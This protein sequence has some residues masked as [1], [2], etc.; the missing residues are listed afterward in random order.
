MSNYNHTIYENYS[1]S[2][3]TALFSSDN[4]QSLSFSER[5]N[6]CQEIE[7]RYAAENNVQPCTVTHQPMNGACYGWQNGNTICLNSYLVAD[8]QFSAQYTDQNGNVQT[9][10]TNALAP[11][12]NTLDTVYHE[13][14]HGIQEQTGRMPS[15][16]ISPEMDGDLYRIQGIEK[17]AYAVG[18]TKTLDALS[19]Y[20]KEVGHLDASRNDYI[21]SVR[22]DSFQ[23]ALSEAARNY[24]DPNVEQTLQ[25]VI[26]DRENNITRKNTTASYDAINNLC[27]TYGIHSSTDITQGTSPDN[28]VESSPNTPISS[29]SSVSEEH[30]S[31]VEQGSST[32]ESPRISSESSVSSEDLQDGSEEDY[33]YTE[34]STNAM[35]DGVEANNTYGESATADLSDGSEEDYQDVSTQGF[36]DGYSDTESTVDYGGSE[37]SYS[38]DGIASDT[39]YDS[40]STSGVESSASDGMDYSD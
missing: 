36:D 12:W 33:G 31:N 7:N 26:N 14:T 2:Q 5:M 21:A 30:P 40:G 13:G 35:D 20:E 28:G 32:T 39:G 34:S 27:E 25:T 16:Y 15:T 24:N 10:R 23:S 18:Q 37:Q 9:V 3:L 11:G 17:E 29:E 38:D 6:A 8:G 4:W 22:N 1:Q 19:N